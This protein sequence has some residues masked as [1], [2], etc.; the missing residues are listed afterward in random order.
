MKIIVGLGNPGEKYEFTRHNTGFMAVDAWAEKYEARWTQNKKFNA[1]VCETAGYTLVKP[2]AFMNNSGQSVRAIM[3]FYQ[4]LPRFAWLHASGSD[5]SDILTVIHDD[6]DIEL[7]KYKISTG[8][9]SAGH[10]GVESIIRHLKTKNFRRLRLGIRTE[11]TA[12]IPT[13]KFV[14]QR[15]GQEELGI[16][17]GIVAEL[18]AE[19]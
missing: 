18:S 3:S 11:F 9:G 19:W 2:T 1:L 16:I 8:S 13:D 4:L 6:I 5:L 15:F 17:N 10:L 7:G 14:L 12:N